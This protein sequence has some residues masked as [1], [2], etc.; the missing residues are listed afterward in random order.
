MSQI[1]N[2]NILTEFPAVDMTSNI[3][4]DSINL[5]S[6]TRFSIQL[7]F[8]GATISGDFTLEASNDLVI[9]NWTTI[10]GT[11]VTIT[12]AGSHLYTITDATYQYIRVVWTDTASAAG[13]ITVAR[14]VIK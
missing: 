5:L 4:G 1:K 9:A 6:D 8:T 3:T 7:V 13:T 11:S 2:E 14:M 10:P 12:A